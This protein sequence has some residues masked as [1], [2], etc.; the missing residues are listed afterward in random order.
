MDAHIEG[1]EDTESSNMVLIC[2]ERKTKE[3]KKKKVGV[4]EEENADSGIVRVVVVW[5]VECRVG[6]G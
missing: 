3:K 1:I 4:R 5:E 2:R 6:K